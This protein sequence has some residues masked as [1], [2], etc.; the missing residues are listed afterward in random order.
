M[1]HKLTIELPDEIFE[2]VCEMARKSGQ[3]PEEWT[4]ER[5]EAIT[6]GA[7]FL[8]PAERAEAKAGFLRHVGT[9]A[10]PD[11]TNADNEAIDRDLAREYGSTHD[12]E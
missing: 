9:V 3:S 4:V 11:P 2:H 7:A 6:P 10:V 5:L 8:T 12:P 1:V